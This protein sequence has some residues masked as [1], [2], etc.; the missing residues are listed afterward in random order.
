MTNERKKFSVLSEE[1]RFSD[2]S[3]ERIVLE[4]AE[5]NSEDAMQLGVHVIGRGLA[6][7]DSHSD[8]MF[9]DGRKSR[10][11]AARLRTQIRIERRRVSCERDEALRGKLKRPILGAIW[12]ENK[13][14]LSPPLHDNTL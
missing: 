6:N 9:R 13:R 4:A 11:S 1:F 7:R 14:L 12:L 3:V 10:T 8:N 5:R 2:R